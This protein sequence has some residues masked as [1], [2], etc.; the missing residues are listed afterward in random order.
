M[1]KYLP[2]VMAIST[3]ALLSGCSTIGTADY[4][5]E[6]DQQRLQEAT[7][8]T[9]TSPHVGHVVWLNPPQKRV[10]VTETAKQQ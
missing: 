5:Y 8:L 9:R 4:A 3:L 6:T 2:I 1:K 10:K 7:A